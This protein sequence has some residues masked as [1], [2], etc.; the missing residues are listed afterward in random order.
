MSD[1]EDRLDGRRTRGRQT[2]ERIVDA[3]LTL[4]EAGD[5]APANARIAEHA[6]ISARLV[7]HHFQDLEELF[8]VAVERRT[9]QILTRYPAPPPGGPLET[10]IAAVVFQRAGLLEWVTPVRLAAMRME[11]YSARLR[12]GRDRMLD[13]ARRQLATLFAPELGPLAEADRAM[14]LAALDAATSWGA[15]HHLRRS[16]SIEDA[17]AAM[18]V[19]VT[20]LLNQAQ[21]RAW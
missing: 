14:M 8:G 1:A 11:P 2:Q 20:A 21:V 5:P 10:R 9:E 15:W 7:Y 18:T 4:I 3:L 17:R 19:S 16:L 12:E 6:G 13:E